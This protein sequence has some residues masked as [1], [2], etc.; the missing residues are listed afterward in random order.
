MGMARIVWTP[1]M[2]ARLIQLRSNWPGILIVADIIGV[3]VPIV[4]RRL[5][6][7]KLPPL[8]RGPKTSPERRA[9]AVT[10]RRLRRADRGH[11]IAQVRNNAAALK[12]TKRY[13]V[14]GSLS[15][16]YN[17]LVVQRFDRGFHDGADA[18]CA[19][20]FGPGGPDVWRWRAPE[21]MYSR[22]GPKE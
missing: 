21:I 9:A 18:F 4:D 10:L 19:G 16:L 5:K 2:D 6:E 14:G 17:G 7:L 20:W 13:N 3:S 15:L 1:E 12:L 8:K 22:K 11:K